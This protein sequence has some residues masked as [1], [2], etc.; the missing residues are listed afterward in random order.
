MPQAPKS[1][2]EKI[3]LV[4]IYGQAKTGRPGEFCFEGDQPVAQS[5]HKPAKM[6]SPCVCLLQQIRQ[7]CFRRDNLGAVALYPINH[8]AD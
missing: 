8:P 3:F 2:F 7:I 1:R 6:T 5:C 4:S